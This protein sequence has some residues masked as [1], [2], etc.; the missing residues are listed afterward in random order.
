[1]ERLYRRSWAE[2]H[3]GY[4]RKNPAKYDT[5]A[6]SQ[7]LYLSILSYQISTVYMRL[8]KPS[9]LFFALPLG[10]DLLWYLVLG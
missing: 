2:E 8:N 6:L 4:T 7:L 1:L 3:S 5:S 9:S 10:T